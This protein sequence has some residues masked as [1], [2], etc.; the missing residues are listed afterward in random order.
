M[1]KLKSAINWWETLSWSACKD[2]IINTSGLTG[3]SD[4]KEFMERDTISYNEVV[5]IYDAAKT[6]S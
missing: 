2:I 4:P 3:I 1:N 6:I 5:A